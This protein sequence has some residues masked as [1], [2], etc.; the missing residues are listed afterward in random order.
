M[1]E[2]KNGE[3]YEGTLQEVD[4]FSNIKLARVIITSWDGEKY[5]KC[6]KVFLRGNS[7][8]T[9]QLAKETLQKAVSDK[10]KD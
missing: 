10:E 2:S 1:V 3:T 5:H 8:K 6:D 4:W 9:F 7:L